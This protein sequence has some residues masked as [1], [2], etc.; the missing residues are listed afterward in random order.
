MQPDRLLHLLREPAGAHRLGPGEWDLL[1]RQARSAGLLAR[2]HRAL[3]E[4]GCLEAVPAP[5]RRH[6]HAAMAVAQRLQDALR[7][8][9]QCIRLALAGTGVSPVL[10]KGAAYVAADLPVARGRVFG[11]VDLLV[12]REAILGVEQALLAH[13]WAPMKLD[14]YDQR[15]YRRWMH[16]IPP[17]EHV[18]RQSVIDVH[19]GILPLTARHRPDPRLILAAARPLPAAPGFQ[20]PAPV[21]LVLHCATH[22]LHEGETDRALRDLLDLDELLRHFGANEP[23]FWASLLPRAQALDLVRPLYYGLRSCR[24]LLG[25][26]VP[27]TV[28]AAVQAHAPASPVVLAMD[29]L[30]REGFR[31]RHRSCRGPLTALAHFLIYVRG[32][33]LRMPLALLLPHLLRKAWPRRS[34]ASPRA[35]PGRA[36]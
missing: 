7:W 24:R 2:L 1:L 14:A 13:G 10:L 22:L 36:P 6:L 15:Y 11:D 32:H 33:W 28:E 21:D 34:P 12:P 27:E 9:L 3:A 29:W 8:E 26:P 17:L 35:A 30:A 23:G 16:E 31:P 4:A 25:T 18:R 19:H 20:V 5:V